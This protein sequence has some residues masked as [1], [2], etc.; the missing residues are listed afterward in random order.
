MFKKKGRTNSFGY[1]P[2]KSFCLNRIH[3]PNPNAFTITL[4]L[5]QSNVIP[6]PTTPSTL[7]RQSQREVIWQTASFYIICDPTSQLD[8]LLSQRPDSQLATR[9]KHN[10]TAGGKGGL[11]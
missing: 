6:A 7:A 3:N 1:E 11:L 8:Q 4:N 9:R 2:E 5:S 10:S